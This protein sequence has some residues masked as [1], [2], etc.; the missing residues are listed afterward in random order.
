MS[1]PNELWTLDIKEF[2][3]HDL[4]MALITVIDDYARSVVG[5]SLLL[6]ACNR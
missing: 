5:H 2:F 3:I 6:S 4:K 1:R